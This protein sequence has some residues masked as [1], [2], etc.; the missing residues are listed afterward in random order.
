MAAP[1]STVDL[2]TDAGV[3]FERG[4]WGSVAVRLDESG[5]LFEAC[6]EMR[7][8]LTGSDVCEARAAANGLHAAILDGIIRKGDRVTIR[9]DNLIVV[10]RLK[11]NKFKKQPALDLANAIQ[12][13]RSIAR[14]NGVGLSFR[15]VKGHSSGADVH[16]AF[17]RRCDI[18]CSDILGTKRTPEQRVCSSRSQIERIAKSKTKV[19]RMQ[20]VLETV[21]RLTG[22]TS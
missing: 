19:R 16:S 11:G 20:G 12:T 9:L 13:V 7:D 8:M 10:Q 15:H 1:K 2:Y 18:L 6:G 22:V 5:L 14:D 4:A 17:N 3:R 21:N